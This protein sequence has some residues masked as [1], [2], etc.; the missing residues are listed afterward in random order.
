MTTAD[1]DPISQISSDVIID[2]DD[3]AYEVTT[4]WWLKELSM[5]H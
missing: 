3:D 2:I 4:L 1:T 5:M